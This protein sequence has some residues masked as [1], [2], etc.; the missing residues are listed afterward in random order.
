[1]AIAGV[2]G[3]VTVPVGRALLAASPLSSTFI[4]SNANARIG[5][6]P[7]DESYGRN[8]HAAGG[9]P[10]VQGYAQSTIVSGMSEMIAQ[11]LGG[12]L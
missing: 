2:S 3:E 9:C 7:T 11:S 12:P 10:I 6:L 5:Y 1:M 4:V 8:T